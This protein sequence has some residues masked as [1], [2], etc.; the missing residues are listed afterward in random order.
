MSLL[1]KN[2]F[3]GKVLLFFPPDRQLTREGRHPSAPRLSLG[4]ASIAMYARHHAGIAAYVYCSADHSPEEIANIIR[5]EKPAVIGVSCWSY[6][7]FACLALARIAKSIDPNIVVVFGGVHATFLDRQI[8][9]HYP[10][11]DYIVRGEGEVTFLKLLEALAGDLDIATIDG[12]T[13][14]RDGTLV[15]YS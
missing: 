2:S 10:E 1:S 5:L 6:N 8:L 9:S 3:H 13:F 12:L 11:V 7:R 14:R 4:L 15:T